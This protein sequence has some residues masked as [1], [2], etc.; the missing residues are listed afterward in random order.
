MLYI[1]GGLF[2]RENEN[3]PD[4]WNVWFESAREN[5]NHRC[6]FTRQS[7]KNCFEES[8]VPIFQRDPNNEEHWKDLN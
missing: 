5:I 4:L 1:G 8:W 6:N 7:I 2:V 3:V